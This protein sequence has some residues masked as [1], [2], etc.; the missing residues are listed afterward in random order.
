MCHMCVFPVIMFKLHTKV[1]SNVILILFAH[2]CFNM[3]NLVAKI[4]Q[5]LLNHSK[6][7]KNNYTWQCDMDSWAAAEAS[8]FSNFL[9]TWRKINIWHILFLIVIEKLNHLHIC[10]FH[11]SA[12]WKLIMFENCWNLTWGEGSGYICK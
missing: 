4:F 6:D 5:M 1:D 8:L 3:N 9:V 2:I 10:N 12:F 11:W 7:T